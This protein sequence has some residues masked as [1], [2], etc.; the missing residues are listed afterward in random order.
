MSDFYEI[1]GVS[2]DASVD[3]IKKA[4]RKL[5][6]KYHPDKDGG[7][8]GKFK[9]INEAYQTLSDNHKRTQYDRFGNAFEGGNPF[10]SGFGGNW[11]VNVSGFEDIGDLS[12]IF[13]S[14]FGG[15]G[16]GQR[17]RT[18][19]K[20]ADIELKTDISLEEAK[21]GKVV[22]LHYDTFAVCNR[23]KGVGHEDGTSFKR[24]NYCSGQGQIKETRNTFF[25]GFAHVVNCPECR[26]SGEIAEKSCGECKGKGRVKEKRT[27]RID[28]RPGIDGGQ[29]IKVNG[30]GEVGENKAGN[31]DLY[32]KVSVMPHPI[33]ERRGNDLHRNV[34]A[35]LVDVILGKELKVEN[36]EGK[37]L[38]VKVPNGF[39]LTDEIRVKGEGM[40]SRGDL[41]LRLDVQIPKHLSKKAKE[42]LDKLNEELS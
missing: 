40:N 30:M 26:G 27:V 1:L 7:D 12:D 10:G 24:C 41:I 38:K 16:V 39:K 11:D 31:G 6:H 4:Y 23:C 35:N 13:S 37:E 8:E 19:N 14:I 9:E 17:R 15:M 2:R 33:F 29:L 20:G 32:V 36:L 34:K 28:I 22:E 18:Y 25:G 5:A 21:K 42:L 3:D